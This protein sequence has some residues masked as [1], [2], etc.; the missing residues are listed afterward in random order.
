MALGDDVFPAGDLHVV[1]PSMTVT[2]YI[3]MWTSRVA[4]GASGTAICDWLDDGST[5]PS[6]PIFGSP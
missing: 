3:G 1:I 6:V 5:V 2:S 4:T